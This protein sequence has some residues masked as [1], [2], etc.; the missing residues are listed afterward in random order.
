MHTETY[1]FKNR[2][3]LLSYQNARYHENRQGLLTYQ[4]NRY[5][6]KKMPLIEYQKKYMAKLRL[7]ALKALADFHKRTVGC[8]CCSEIVIEFMTIDHKTPVSKTEEER[9][10]SYDTLVS[11]INGVELEK[12][13]IFCYNCNMGKRA[14]ADCPHEKY[15]NV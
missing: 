6:I 1:Y 8:F 5:D 13:Q 14:N 9:M 11:L 7:K 2:E 15:K 3:K 10:N 12:Y 4:N